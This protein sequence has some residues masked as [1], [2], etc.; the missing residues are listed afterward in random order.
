MGGNRKGIIHIFYPKENKFGKK[1]K[2]GEK[3][4]ICKIQERNKDLHIGIF[5]CFLTEMSKKERR[6]KKKK[7]SYIKFACISSHPS[8]QLAVLLA[9]GSTSVSTHWTL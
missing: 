2:Q 5:S 7:E 9:G 4:I 8:S 6:E 3:D 1:E